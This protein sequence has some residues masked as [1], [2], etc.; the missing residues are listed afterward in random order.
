MQNKEKVLIIIKPDALIRGYFGE[1]VSRFER[2]GLKII[3]TKMA[4]LEDVILEEHYN[5]LADKPFFGRIK[6]F[7]QSAPVILMVLS[8]VNAVEATRLIV[9]PTDGSKADAGSI[10]GDFSLSIQSNL[11]HASDSPENGE[12]ETFIFFSKD[13]IYEYMRAGEDVIYSHINKMDF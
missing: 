10:R 6:E 9:G 7:M 11:V 8:G 12:K 13:E 5:H 1:V 2:K 4:K 3:A